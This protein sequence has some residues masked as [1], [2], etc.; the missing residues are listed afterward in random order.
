MILLDGSLSWRP[1]VSSCIVSNGCLEF[2]FS[3]DL[4]LLS[5]SFLSRSRSTISIFF[6]LFLKL[7]NSDQSDRSLI[8]LSLTALLSSNSQTSISPIDPWLPWVLLLSRSRTTISIFSLYSFGLDHWLDLSLFKFSNLDQSNRSL[9]ALSF[10]A[11][12]SSNSQTSISPTDPWLPWV[13]LLSRSR[14]TIS[15]FSLVVLAV[16]TTVLTS[17]SLK[18]TNIVL[19]FVINTK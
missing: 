3:V 10:T 12:L 5:R 18:P 15:I 11:L 17:L 1:W 13:L 14:T 19:E 8:A 7:S 9:V 16:S 6:S 4:D 2:Y